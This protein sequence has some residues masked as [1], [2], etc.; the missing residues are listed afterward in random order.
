MGQGIAKENR[1]VRGDPM[2][3]FGPKTPM[4]RQYNSIDLCK[5]IMAFAVVAIHTRPFV[6]AGNSFFL[7]V[8][9]NFVALAVPFFFL[10]SG[11]LLAVKMEDPC[12]SERDL[13][14][15]KK[16][17]RS[18]VRL[19]LIWTLVYAPLELFY[20]VASKT[21]VVKAV[22]LYI[23]GVF[24]IGELFSSWQL[25]YLLSTIYALILIGMTLKKKRGPRSLAIISIIAGLV[26]F[27]ST[28]LVAYQ[29][30][31][32][33][34]LGIA[35]KLI[36]ISI[37]NGRIFSGMVYIPM[38]MLLAH[39]KIPNRINWL[40]FLVGFLANCFVTNG[41][42]SHVL[43]VMTA[44]SFFGIVADIPLGNSPVYPKLRRMSSIIYLTHMYIWTFYYLIMYR[45][46]TPGPDSF[47]VTSC[48]AVVI[49]ALVVNKKRR[50]QMRPPYRNS[51]H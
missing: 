2:E 21:P 4:D 32:P 48:V 10:A 51:E 45:Q 8:Y 1:N 49:A 6:N 38:G 13:L 12:G 43:L 11:Y 35:Q 9:E 31:L 3:A 47:A 46:M 19:Y 5:F 34:F 36:R 24:L 27:G 28:E 18:T 44:L 22:L 37:A 39:R 25:W 29:G 30:D 16:Q 26:S 14:R 15:V 23:R 33:V 17:L 20:L 41:F 50:T 42:V 7:T 40:L